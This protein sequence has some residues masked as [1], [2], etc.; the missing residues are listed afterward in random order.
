M[1]KTRCI[2]ASSLDLRNN[3]AGLRPTPAP[4]GMGYGGGI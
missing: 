1:R 2:S 3:I 4:A